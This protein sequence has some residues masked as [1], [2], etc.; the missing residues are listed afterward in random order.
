MHRGVDLDER[1]SWKFR[2]ESSETSLLRQ[3]KNLLWDFEV[4]YIFLKC[5]IKYMLSK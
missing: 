1:L 5:S 3:E 4:I 2:I